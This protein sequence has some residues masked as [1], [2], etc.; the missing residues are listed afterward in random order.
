MAIVVVVVAAVVV[1]IAVVLGARVVVAA[2]L[3]VGVDDSAGA[4]VALS[5]LDEHAASI[6]NA[7]NKTAHRRVSMIMVSVSS[8]LR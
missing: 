2:A 4:V 1:G 6:V 7:N 8:E 5:S 3:V